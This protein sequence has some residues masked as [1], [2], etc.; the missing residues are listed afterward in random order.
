MQD[1]IKVHDLGKHLDVNGQA[2]QIKFYGTNENP[3]TFEF[4]SATNTPLT[5]TNITYLN[6]TIIEKSHNLFWEPIPF[7]LLKTYETEPQVIISVDGL[8]AVCHSMDCGFKFV[9]AIGAMTT[10]TFDEAT[11]ELVITGVALPA[12]EDI[13]FVRFA[14]ANCVVDPATLT[15]ETIICTLD[16]DP[17]GG[18]WQPTLMSLKGTIPLDL[19]APTV[20]I[21]TTLTVVTPDTG[22]NTQGGDIL[23]FTGTFLPSDLLTSTVEIAFSDSGSTSCVSQSTTSTELTCITSRF[24][25]D[26]A[27]QL[28]VTQD[29]AVTIN[30]LAVT[31]TL[32]VTMAGTASAYALMSPSSVSPVLKTDITFTFGGDSV[33]GTLLREDFTV[34]VTNIESP[35][36]YKDLRVN[37]VDDAAKTI[38]AKF[39]GAWSGDYSVSIRHSTQGD[40]DTASL[41]LRVESDVTSVTPLTGSIYGGTLLTITGTN[42]GSEITDNP[43]E[44]SY[45]GA[46]DS[47]KCYVETTSATEITCRVESKVRESGKTGKVIVFLKTY[48]EANCT[49][50]NECTWTYTDAIPLV[51]AAESV[52]D[53]V[54]NTWQIRVTGEGVSGDTSNVELIV[55]GTKQTTVSVSDTEALFRI[56]DISG[57]TLDSM[58]LFFDVGIPENS[59]LLATPIQLEPKLVEVSPN[60]GS[61]GGTLIVANVQGVGPGI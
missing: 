48:E 1:K 28:G 36:Y 58:Q 38:T 23:T 54:S 53:D 22:L 31:H 52:F 2:F 45:N 27:A 43:V 47:T 60:Q 32:T 11:F 24:G 29:I 26:P 19:A 17:A 51:T 57:Q 8:P 30:G 15:T 16:R 18:D 35:T 10:F 61:A 12:E 46:L 34:R 56:D 49:N 14:D 7:E 6:A 3:G 9:E 20:T 21:T 41:L 5:G 33:P 55:A 4:M 59:G 42:W 39:G 37:S 25:P 44:I 40:L 13:S 50:A